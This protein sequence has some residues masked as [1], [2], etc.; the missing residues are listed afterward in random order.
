MPAAP[1]KPAFLPP[2][3]FHAE[4]KRLVEAHFAA[5]GRSPRGG[6]RLAVKGALLLAWFAGSWSALVLGHPPWWLAVPLAVSLGLAWAGVGFNVMH[7]ANHGASTTRAGWNRLLAYSSD[8]IGG[9]SV[10]WRHKHNVLHHGYTN[11]LGVDEDLESGG[12]LRLARGQP[13]RPVHR[14]QHLYVWVLY[15]LFPLRWF[16]LDDFRD[17]L[18]RRV[19]AS[20]LPRPSPGAVAL[21]LLGKLLFVGWALV[22]PLWL[23]PWSEVLPLGLVA[24]GTLGVTL[25]TVFQLAH[26]VGEARFHAAA[27]GPV[28]SDWATYQVASTVDFARGSRLCAWYLGGLNFQ[29]VHHLFPTVSHVHYPDLAP[30]VERCCRRHGVPY[31]AWDTLRDALG[32]NVRWLRELGL[33]EAPG[34]PA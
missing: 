20:P 17:L 19:G 13:R 16:L 21:L 34:A 11:V 31:R 32:A 4:L 24:V 22:V 6:W 5:S 10:I 29:V 23:H 1:T 3:P 2:G 14:L 26:A 9:S 8:L 28:P 7:D 18:T 15:A 25:A 27:A 33:P 12:L 30:I